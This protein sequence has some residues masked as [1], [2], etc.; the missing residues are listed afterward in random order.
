MLVEPLLMVPAQPAVI[1]DNINSQV[2][3]NHMP[4]YNSSQ[5]HTLMH[6]PTTWVLTE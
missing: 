2:Y 3:G 4:A 6:K 5:L 1:E